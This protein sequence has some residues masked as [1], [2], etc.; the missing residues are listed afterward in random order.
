MKISSQS[1]LHAGVG[2]GGGG[3]CQKNFPMGVF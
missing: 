2:G 3:I 1:A